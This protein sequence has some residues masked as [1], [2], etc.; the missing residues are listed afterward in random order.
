MKRLTLLLLLVS[1][2]LAWAAKPA[3]SGQ[4]V[5]RNGEPVSRAVISL[6]PGGVRI[7]TDAEGR[8]LIDYLRD[9]SGDRVRL[10]KRVEYAVE[11]FKP[12]FHIVERTMFYE[13]GVALMDQVVLVEETVAVTDDR[14][15]LDPTLYGSTGAS[16]GAAYE[17]Q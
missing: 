7:V 11:V 3:I 6:A 13:R 12:G 10:K 14:A 15:R 17:G 1:P 16:E 4:V 9:E 5:D 2:T 8:F